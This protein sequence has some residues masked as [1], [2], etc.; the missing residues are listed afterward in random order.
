MAESEP[1]MEVGTRF[2]HWSELL[3]TFRTAVVILENLHPGL[4]SAADLRKKVKIENAIEMIESQLNRFSN[5]E[6]MQFKLAQ[7]I[8]RLPKAEDI[9]DEE[10]HQEESEVETQVES[11]EIRGID[12]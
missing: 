5:R 1:L 3:D 9:H 7:E 4:G 12:G 2:E 11:R 6:D 10:S 8:E